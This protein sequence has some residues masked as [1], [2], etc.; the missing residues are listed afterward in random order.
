MPRRV[1]PGVRRVVVV[2]TTSVARD[3]TFPFMP[4]EGQCL[5][6]RLC[7][8]PCPS[9][10]QRRGPAPLCGNDSVVSGGLKSRSTR[11]AAYSVPK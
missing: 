2:L 7:A 5:G 8:R 1:R 11:S 4:A 9:S 6:R 10:S 3:L